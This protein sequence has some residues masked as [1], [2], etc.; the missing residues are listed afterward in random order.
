MRFFWAADTKHVSVNFWTSA[1]NDGIN[2]EQTWGWCP[3]G[4]LLG[5]DVFWAAGEPN[6]MYLENCVLINLYPG[7]V[8]LNK[9][10]SYACATA[11]RF[12]CEVCL[13]KN[14]FDVLFLTASHFRKLN[15]LEMRLY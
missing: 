14:S 3:N 12:I 5:K 10:Y 15:I 13:A 6:Y 4:D 8:N 9:L 1:T 2:R 7:A 11:L